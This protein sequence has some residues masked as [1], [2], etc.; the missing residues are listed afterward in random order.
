MDHKKRRPEVLER[1][2][3]MHA[4]KH[5][6]S[7]EDFFNMWRGTF[8]S[9][10]KYPWEAFSAIRGLFARAREIRIHCF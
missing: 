1:A 9:W 4:H 5:N 10:K 6:V 2:A 3:R 7:K 8:V